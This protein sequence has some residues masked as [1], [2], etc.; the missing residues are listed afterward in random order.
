ME[1]SSFWDILFDN[2]NEGVYVLNGAGDYIYCNRAFLK[3]VGASREE[4]L[5]L[6]A[7]R[8]VPEGQVKRSVAVSAFEEKRRCSMVNTVSTPKGHRY[9]QLATA[10]PIFDGDGAVAYVLVE[11]VLV[12][13]LERRLQ[14][15][16]LTEDED[17]V[18]VYADLSPQAVPSVV[19]DSAAMRSVLS[20]A[21]Q[22]AGADSAVLIQGETGS[23]KEVVAN[24][25]HQHSKRAKGELVVINCAALPENLLEAELFGYEKGAFTG[26]L[27]T[28]K[29]GLVEKA[30]GGTLFLD[31]VNSLP[32]ALQ[33][34]LLRLLETKKSQR[35]GAMHEHALD[36]RL[37]SASNEDL[38]ACVAAGTFRAD[39]YY[40]L[41][42][43]P[44]WVPP[45]RERPED[46]PPLALRFLDELCRQYGRNRVLSRGVLDQL[47]RHSWPGNVRELKN[48]VER[49]FITSA[50]QALEITQLPEH[51]LSG[52]E[53][54]ADLPPAAPW[55]D[56]PLD[57]PG[58]SLKGYLDA[59]EADI[60]AQALRRT[61]STYEAARLLGTNQSTVVRKKQKHEL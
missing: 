23:G 26:A 46:I 17:V 58:F 48:V 8:L 44:L 14:Q 56:C 21:Q 53:T 40:R 54:T 52:E 45:L 35:L 32:L 49:L 15:A 9:R 4:V 5:R 13:L 10:T 50:P 41:S 20:L 47:R 7:F 22:V 42:V 6:N 51:L 19:A 3:M 55:T 11:M 39:L 43:I 12:D 60:V 1:E 61:G 25:L 59:C 29:P 38:K 34:K 37:L 2:I 33:G 57:R 30:E 28:G 18:E 16:L 24:Y 27:H 36:F 31:E